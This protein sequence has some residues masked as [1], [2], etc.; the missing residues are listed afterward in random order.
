MLVMMNDDDDD[1]DGV[2]LC[3]TLSK[4]LLT[5]DHFIFTIGYNWGVR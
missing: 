3:L 2:T 4:K 5:F 1:D